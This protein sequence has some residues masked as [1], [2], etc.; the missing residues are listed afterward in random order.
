MGKNKENKTQKE[1]NLESF[2]NFNPESNIKYIPGAENLPKLRE[3]LQHSPIFSFKYIS[4]KGSAYC[5]DYSQLNGKNYKKV[6]ERFKSICATT[7]QIME[8]DTFNYRFHSIKF[9]D[10]RVAITKQF[11][12]NT[13]NENSP[14]KVKEEQLPT[15]YQ[16]KIFEEKRA[17]GFL[18]YNGEFNLIWLD[19]D[20]SI[21]PR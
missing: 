4:L 8:S 19:F 5:F 13:L 3:Q 20:H 21:Y 14:S 6:I 18:G 2:K 7:Y 16:F 1:K 17:V 10:K 12:I 11:Y 15:L 9:E